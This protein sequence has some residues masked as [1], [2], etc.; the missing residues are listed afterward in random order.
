MPIR[1]DLPDYHTHTWRCGHASGRAA[2]YV[3]AARRFGLPGIGISDHLPLPDYP[4]PSVC[5][6]EDDLDDYVDEVL[7]LKTRFPGFV[8]LGIEA[9]YLPN[10]VNDLRSLL[11]AYPFDYVIGSVHFLDDW[12][13]DNEA[14]IEEF[15]R[16]DIDEIYV[17][18]YRLIGEAAETGLFTIIGHLDLVKKFGHRPRSNLSQVIETALT[19]IAR[20]GAVLEINTAGLRKPVHE[21]Y[22]EIAVLQRARALGVPITFGSDAHTPREVGFAFAEAKELAR[23][24]GYEA[25]VR[26]IP[27]TKARARVE[28]HSF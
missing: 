7:E 24:A 21:I 13:F 2:D 1:A 14:Q 6:P 23:L 16:R 17:R 20:S 4:D 15:S 18:Y 28:L 25:W 26:L 27:Q 19:C 5:M 12:G 10:R 3:D 22:P 8:L 11:E 9:D